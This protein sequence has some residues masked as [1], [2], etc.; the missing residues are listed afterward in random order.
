MEAEHLHKHDHHHNGD[1][2]WE[3]IAI[4]LHLPG[5]GH[6]H[7]IPGRQDAIFN[8]E[9]GIK[10]VKQALLLLG[11]TTLLQAGIYFFSGSVALLADTVHNFGDAPCPMGLTL[12]NPC[13]G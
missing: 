6:S 12:R 10:I 11:V 7:A 1:S 5:Y 3:K 8:N 4:A 13:L 2:W 9:L